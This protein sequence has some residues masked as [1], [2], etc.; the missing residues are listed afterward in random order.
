MP[1]FQLEATPQLQRRELGSAF[2]LLEGV[3]PQQPCSTR[4]T[5]VVID[6]LARLPDEA[7][8]TT[9]L[10]SILWPDDQRFCMRCGNNKTCRVQSRRP[11]PHWC[12][13]CRGYFSVRTG[14]VLQRSSLPHQKWVL[15]PLLMMGGPKSMSSYRM[16]DP[17]GVTQKTACSLM[18]K[19]RQGFSPEGL[20]KLQGIVEINEAYLGGREKNKH[21]K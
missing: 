18:H 14:T 19:I 16:A 13:E 3:T 5:D 6:L 21:G 20:G 7:V 10:E 8:T 2:V 1:I 12:G 15:A 11:M 17:I 4:N 9:W